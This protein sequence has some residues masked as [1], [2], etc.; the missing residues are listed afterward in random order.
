M[1]VMSIKEFRV[2]EKMN[3]FLQWMFEGKIQEFPFMP[4]SALS[5]RLVGQSRYGLTAY[6]IRLDK[7]VE[8]VSKERRRSLDASE[9]DNFVRGRW[10][11]VFT[12]ADEVGHIDTLRECNKSAFR[13]N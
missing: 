2:I 8:A 10:E 7:I 13:S 9:V 5:Q 4:P 12:H 11:D 6:L 1:L 3:G